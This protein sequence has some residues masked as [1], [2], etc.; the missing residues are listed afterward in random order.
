MT[1]LGPGLSIGKSDQEAGEGEGNRRS[2]LY[3]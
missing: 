2:G 1:V 3:F